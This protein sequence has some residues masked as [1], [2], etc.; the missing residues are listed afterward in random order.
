MKPRKTLLLSLL[1][2]PAMMLSSCV[3]PVDPYYGPYYAGPA[4]PAGYPYYFVGGVYYSGGRY[5]P[6]R[7]YY[8][9]RWYEG[10][11]FYRGHYYY[12]GHWHSGPVH[13]H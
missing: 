11:Y 4:V 3:V 10:R 12:G 5:Y 13:H 9:G 2:A 1:A 8:N 7:C 6:G